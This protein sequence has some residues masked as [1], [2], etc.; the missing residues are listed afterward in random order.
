[1]QVPRIHPYVFNGRIYVYSSDLYM[2]RAVHCHHSI[3][4]SFLLP[5][6]S[7][8]QITR[9]VLIHYKHIKCLQSTFPWYSL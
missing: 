8:V 1:M 7:A 2:M 3:L 6:R 9:C 4:Y 5:L